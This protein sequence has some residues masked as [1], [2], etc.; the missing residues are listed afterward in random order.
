[1]FGTASDE[2]EVNVPASEAWKVYGSLLLGKI[3][4]ESLS[5]FFSKIVA[6]GDG[7]VGTTI[8]IFFPSGTY[9]LVVLGLMNLKR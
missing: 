1:M 7:G 9:L 8:E 5:E 2:R 3:A 6:H 4:G